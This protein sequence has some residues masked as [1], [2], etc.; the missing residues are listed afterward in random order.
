MRVV[1]PQDSRLYAVA[2]RVCGAIGRG[3]NVGARGVRWG[4]WGAV[5][6]REPAPNE[7]RCL[8]PLRRVRLKIGGLPV[9]TGLGGDLKEGQRGVVTPDHLDKGGLEPVKDV[10]V[11]GGVLCQGDDACE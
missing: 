10:L 3:G 7:I 1:S 6:A 11:R 2:S 5:A 8:L 9:P 4:E